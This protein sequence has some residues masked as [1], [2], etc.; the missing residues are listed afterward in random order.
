MT[1]TTLGYL[2]NLMLKFLNIP[3]QISNHILCHRKLAL[4]SQH[5]NTD[6]LI[7]K[8]S[9]KQTLVYDH[10][11]PAWQIDPPSLFMCVCLFCQQNSLNN[12]YT[13]LISRC[14]YKSNYFIVYVWIYMQQHGS[15]SFIII[16][17]SQLSS[18]KFTKTL[19]IYISVYVS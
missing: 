3:F 19:F 15:N 12:S 10:H 18:L 14:H 4:D 11:A 17:Y 7:F 13:I 16:I 5:F 2:L 6:I 1:C 9:E 8:F